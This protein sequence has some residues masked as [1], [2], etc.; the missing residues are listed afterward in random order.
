MLARAR[1]PQT[2]ICTRTGCEGSCE[3]RRGSNE[4]DVP[5]GCTDTRLACEAGW[6]ALPPADSYKSSC[7]LGWS[8]EK[9][10][11]CTLCM[12]SL[13]SCSGFW[14]PAGGVRRGLRVGVCQK[15]KG[16]HPGSKVRAA[17]WRRHRS[18][19][20]IQ[21]FAS[22]PT[23]TAICCLPN[24]GRPTHRQH[25]AIPTAKAI[26]C[27]PNRIRPT[28]RPCTVFPIA[29]CPST[30]NMLQSIQQKPYA[31]SPTAEGP[32]AGHARPVHLHT[33]KA[34]QQ[35]PLTGHAVLAAA[36][37]RGLLAHAREQARQ[38]FG[39]PERG[40][41][42]RGAHGRILLGVALGGPLGPHRQDEAHAPGRGRAGVGWSRRLLGSWHRDYA[43]RL[44]QHLGT[45]SI[46]HAPPSLSP[47][48]MTAHAGTGLH[49]VSACCE[50][51]L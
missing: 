16:I 10:W 43:H 35:A 30:G 22:I 4:E 26:C 27:L 49:A 34:K 13:S 50:C 40:R 3:G 23:A 14:A 45:V 17:A 19:P 21:P 44:M 7:V 51:M 2:S 32:P 1:A 25:A 8:G 28:H 29:A 31:A 42:E 47:S 37:G 36:Q 20:T 48:P 5:L 18:R 6:K 11:L 41:Q 12:R 24:R 39:R 15:P 33:G 38:V 9:G 46:S